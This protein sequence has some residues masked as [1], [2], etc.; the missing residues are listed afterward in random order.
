MS[1][2]EKLYVIQRNSNQKVDNNM[3]PKHT[4]W[5][6]ITKLFNLESRKWAIIGASIL[7]VCS[8]IVVMI[9]EFYYQGIEFFLTTTF[10]LDHFIVPILFTLIGWTGGHYYGKTIEV[11]KR[12]EQALKES[13]EK[14]QMLIEKLEEGVLL[15][16]SEGYTSFVNP[17]TV[18]MLGYT[19]E[20]LLGK[21]WSFLA[22]A[23]DLNKM[24]AEANKRPNG[25][26]STYEGG[27]QAKNGSIIPVIITA[28]PI[29]SNN[30]EFKGVLSVFTDITVR[31]RMEL[32]LTES[33]EK[34]QMLVEELEEGVLLED[35]EGYIS[36]VNPKTAEMLQY[37]TEELLG[38]YWNNMMVVKDLIRIKAKSNKYLKGVIGTYEG[39]LQAKDGSKIPV[40]IT[41][42]P[43]YNKS[44]FH[45]VLSVITDITERKR[46]EEEKEDL[47]KKRAD[48]ISMTSHEL[49]TPLTAIK[50]YG[51]FLEKHFKAISQDKIQTYF[52]MITKNIKRLERLIDGVS[53]LGSIERGLFKLELTKTNF[54][55]FLN[56]AMQPYIE[57][58]SDQFEYVPLPKEFK[59][60]CKIDES[61]L[62]HVFNNIIDNA[63]KHT[64]RKSRK[65]SVTMEFLPD[66]IRVFI[67]DNGAGIKPINLKRIFDPFTSFPTSHSVKGTGIGLFV[68]QVIIDH[69]NGF[70]TA[71]SDG[72]GK[73]SA[74]I[75]ELPRLVDS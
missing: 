36:F 43:I 34:Y 58:L 42:T 47:E 57:L 69:H 14:Y 46:M 50:G 67:K 3:K 39:R 27:L 32:A 41:S 30:G 29:F 33:K 60:F 73:G 11:R 25:V 65:I 55:D 10:T 62:L 21:H 4:Y 48:F 18:E 38:K 44:E 2:P 68:S 17:K 22:A 75:V 23:E 6:R 59:V 66:I 70:I 15:E 12:M 8:F 71:Y 40:I 16:D 28:T 20:E 63:I 35:S 1:T 5:L 9:E 54:T 49:R 64:E 13:K 45:G 26:S 56:E 51:M 31:K 72:E 74:F 37:S 24:K 53:V 7:S 61:S 19:E 52:N